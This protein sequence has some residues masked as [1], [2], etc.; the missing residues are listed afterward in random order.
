MFKQVVSFHIRG[1]RIW[2]SEADWQRGNISCLSKQEK[3][4]GERKFLQHL[5][6]QGKKKKD[7]AIISLAAVELSL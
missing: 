1:K 2:G 5:V 3:E 6:L 7:V 4:K